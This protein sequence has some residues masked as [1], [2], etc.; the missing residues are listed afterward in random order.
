VGDQYHKVLKMSVTRK[1][2]VMNKTR[3]RLFSCVSI[4]L[5]LEKLYYFYNK[6]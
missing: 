5:S 3:A 2:A 1:N 4:L 6:K